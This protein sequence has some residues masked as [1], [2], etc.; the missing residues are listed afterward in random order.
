MEA[1][2][3]ANTKFDLKKQFFKL[4]GSNFRIYDPQQNMVLFS[5]QKGFKLRGDIRI[6]YDEGGSQEA[7]SVCAR[8][9]I[10][11]SAAY[12]VVDS[13][14]HQK[15]GAFKR[16][17]WASL[18]RDEWIVMDVN[19]REIGKVME[20]S[21]LLGLLRRFLSNWIPQNYDMLLLDGSRVADY[22]QH[23]NPFAYWLTMDFTMDPMKRVDPRMKLAAGVLLAAVEG[24]Q[25][26]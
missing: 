11:F 15:I 1:N 20:D 10:D 12:D 23:W 25:R 4:V 8:E 3:W 2:V 19:D 21:V 9:I 24:K 13:Q 22:R 17:G 5:H 26:S 14:T 7:L 6:Y 18:V 16:K